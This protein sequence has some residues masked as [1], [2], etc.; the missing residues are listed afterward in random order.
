M[1][2]NQQIKNWF[3]LLLLALIWGSSFLLMKRGMVDKFSGSIVF[4]NI[5]VASIRMFLASFVL[6]PFG[7]RYIILYK[8]KFKVIYWL[9]I[10]AFCG[11]FFPAFLFT[12][13]ETGIDS[14]LAGMLNSCTPI[15]ILIMGVSF[16]KASIN[17]NN[18]LGILVGSIGIIWLTGSVQL[19]GSLLKILAVI[20][21]T[22]CYAVSVLTIK[23]KLQNIKP[24]HIT[25][26]AFVL[27]FIPSSIMLNYSNAIG[28]FKTNPLAVNSFYYI[29]VL[30]L[31]GTCFAVILFNVL[32]ANSSALFAGS[33]TYLIPIVAVIIG[34]FDGEKILFYQ[35]IAMFVI[36]GGI[37]LANYQTQKK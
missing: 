22:F 18:L 21:A 19:T 30:A 28:M 6:L 15:F 31:I 11:N 37:Y 23:Y 20:L 8:P 17:K 14:S 33:V 2:L 5:Q 34:F 27:C 13:A 4:D 3:L 25:S 35:V 26:M 10:V 16:F 36:I 24:L 12:Y 9:S 29:L 32:I 1:N 7:V